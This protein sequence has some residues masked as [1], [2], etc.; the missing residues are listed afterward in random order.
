MK[1][2]K[3]L[4]EEAIKAAVQETFLSES[5]KEGVKFKIG[6]KEME[7]GGTEHV[8]VLKALLK[9]M[10]SLRDCYSPGSANRHVYSS[11]CHKLKKLITKHGGSTGTP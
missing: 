8:K 5:I 6:S 2:T 3:T 11:A 4:V 9:G 1:D 10:Q 7:F